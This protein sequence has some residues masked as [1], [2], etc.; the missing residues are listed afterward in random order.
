MRISFNKIQ[1]KAKLEKGFVQDAYYQKQITYHQDR[2]AKLSKA[3]ES[4]KVSPILVKAYISL[5]KE[6]EELDIKLIIKRLKK[7]AEQENP[8]LL[9]LE[10]SYEEIARRERLGIIAQGK[11]RYQQLTIAIKLVDLIDEICELDF[12]RK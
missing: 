9:A 4:M 6:F 2:L 11:V 7:F 10:R 5:K 3:Q 8:K 1:Q 12:N